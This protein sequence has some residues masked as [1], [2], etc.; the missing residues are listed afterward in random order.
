MKPLL[1]MRTRGLGGPVALKYANL[2]A[3]VVKSKGASFSKGGVAITTVSYKGE[4]VTYQ[5]EDVTYG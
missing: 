4:I 2:T 5:G 1:M 3:N